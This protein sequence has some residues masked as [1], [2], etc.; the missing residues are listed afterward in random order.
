MKKRAE[1]RYMS[2]LIFVLNVIGGESGASFLNL[3]QSEVTQ[4]NTEI[5]DYFRLLDNQNSITTA[6]D[7]RQIRNHIFF[8]QIPYRIAWT[9]GRAFVLWNRVFVFQ[10]NNFFHF[11]GLRFLRGSPTRDFSVSEAEP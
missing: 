7:P 5:S 6:R 9:L 8:L 1:K 11:G 2:R 4:K 3:S 10:G